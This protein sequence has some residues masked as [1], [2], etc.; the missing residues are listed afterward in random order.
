MDHERFRNMAAGFQSIVISLAVVVGGLWSAYTFGVLR[1][2]EDAK[3][4]IESLTAPSLSIT[5]D[6]DRV[7]AVSPNRIGL[8]VRIRA[9]N[10]GGQ[11]LQLDLRENPLNVALVEPGT[12]GH[13]HA[14]KTYQ[15]IH[16]MDIRGESYD[17]SAAYGIEIKS[18][19]TLNYYIEVDEP[20]L[21]F[22]RFRAP[23]GKVGQYFAAREEIGRI[24]A[25]KTG[26][27]YVGGYWLSTTFVD[28]R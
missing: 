16:Y 28:L 14:K 4:K 6:T 20:G 18:K 19:K 12:D 7:K 22:V 15:P 13:L 10:T 5:I 1:T 26:L 17:K 9:E 8:I 24:E 3:A 11:N 25:E 2:V 21:Y 23:L 27:P